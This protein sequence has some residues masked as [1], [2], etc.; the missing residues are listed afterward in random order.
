MSRFIQQDSSKP[1]KDPKPR[2]IPQ[3]GRYTVK[4][5]TA[6]GVKKTQQEKDHA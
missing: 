1:K 3:A 4:D 6:D 5:I 2:T